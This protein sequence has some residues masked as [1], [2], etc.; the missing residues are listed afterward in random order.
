MVGADADD[1][2]RESGGKLAD[3]ARSVSSAMSI[4]T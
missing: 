1:M 3:E 4:G 2:G